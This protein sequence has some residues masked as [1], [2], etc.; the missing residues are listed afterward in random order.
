[1]FLNFFIPCFSV[2]YLGSILV[3]GGRIAVQQQT[4]V[5]A[6]CLIVPAV[7]LEQINNYVMR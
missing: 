5:T 2:G 6:D 7:L 4:T 1:M 3:F